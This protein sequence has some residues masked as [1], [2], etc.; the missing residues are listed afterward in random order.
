MTIVPINVDPLADVDKGRMGPA[1]RDLS[2]DVRR[3]GPDAPPQATPPGRS[4]E[5]AQA[6]ETQKEDAPAGFSTYRFPAD[7]AEL[8][9]QSRRRRGFRSRSALPDG[10]HEIQEATMAGLWRVRFTGQDASDRRLSGSLQS[11]VDRPPRRA[12]R[13]PPARLR[14]SAAG[15]MN[16]MPCPQEIETRANAHQPGQPTTATLL[17]AADE[18]GRHGPICSNGSA[19]A[20][21]AIFERLSSFGRRH[22]H[23]ERLLRGLSLTR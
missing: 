19:R 15:A 12:R 8:M 13:T 23:E 18:R 5:L 4:P 1:P 3:R 11:I 9:K 6:L 16:V 22:R 14:P 10:R 2:G 17:A 20:G 7:D 21:E